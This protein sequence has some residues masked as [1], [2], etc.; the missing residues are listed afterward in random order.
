MLVYIRTGLASSP[1]SFIIRFRRQ[2]FPP[3]LIPT[4]PWLIFSSYSSNHTLF[5]LRRSVRVWSLLATIGKPP[6][7]IADLSFA[8]LCPPYNSRLK[9]VK[10][11]QHS[12]NE[13]CEACA[14]A[15]VACR[16]RDRER[17]FAERSRIMA[18]TS[19]DTTRRSAQPSRASSSS[20]GW[21]S[22]NGTPSPDRDVAP[23]I[24]PSNAT[25]RYTEFSMGSSYMPSWSEYPQST[26]VANQYTS[27]A[28]NSL[29][30]THWYAP[31]PLG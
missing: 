7:S 11:I 28:S 19:P 14:N 23:T 31:I 8:Y 5:N 20:T 21:N 22:S 24:V 3:P 27:Q 4:S 12:P 6:S 29:N 30:S 15:S 1:S 2:S 13:K 16:F 10:C 18:G 17:Y 25:A 26:S 9:K